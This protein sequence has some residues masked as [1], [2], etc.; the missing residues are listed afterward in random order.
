MIMSL[1]LIVSMQSDDDN[2]H[3][4]NYTV[5]CILVDEGSFVV[6]LYN[7]IVKVM[8]ILTSNLIPY[9]KEI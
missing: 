3:H 4:D 1:T 9:P 7:Y 6:I 5:K 2:N 8:H